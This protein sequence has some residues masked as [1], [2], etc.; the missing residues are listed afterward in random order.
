MVLLRMVGVWIIG[1]LLLL[2]QSVAAAQEP[3]SSRRVDRR[4]P[5]MAVAQRLPP[6]ET[7]S[8]EGMEDGLFAGHQELHVTD[9]VEL[10]VARNPSVEALAHAWRAA[11]QR[12]PQ[13]VSLDDPM[14]MAMMAPA[15]LASQDVEA[16]YVLQGSQKFQLHG[17][18]AAK[19][20]AAAAEA[21]VALNELR[22]A[23]LEVTQMAQFAYYDYYLV[24]QKIALLRQ[25]ARIMREFRDSANSKYENNLVTEQDVLQADIELADVERRQIELDRLNVTAIARINTLLLRIPDD[26]LP[27]PP[28][29][30]I[31][32]H[33]VPPVDFLRQM[34]M[35]QRPDLA[36]V[37]ARVR[38]EQANLT[39]ATKQYYPDADVFGRYD[40]FWQPVATQ[41]DLR[42]Q[43]GV[44]INVPIYHRRLSAGVCE[45]RFRV[46]QRQAEYEQKV[47]DIQYEVQNAY[48]EVQ[49]SQKT[50]EL[51]STKF[52][53]TADRN[54]SVARSNY[55][56]GQITF[57][58]LAQAQR[59]AV[60]LRE[61]HQEALA[62]Y[63]RRLAELERVVGSALPEL[64]S[65]ES[66]ELP[67]PDHK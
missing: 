39:L 65:K 64:A 28:H 51:Y 4:L 58:G 33:E 20:R 67:L 25:N 32:P 2:L 29:Q 45:A 27:P 55:D 17:K 53:P 11:A 34:A 13:V 47:A 3:V 23:R 40:S 54:A 1:G 19:G 63:H 44:N 6:V 37:A 8:I 26:F 24:Q 56:V 35:G 14:F 61:K 7:V 36:A 22:D 48:A 12:Y 62:D 15:S 52:L 59:Q 18:R 46:A 5:A 38:A 16:G 60:E 57:L 42:G 41:S 10:A 50:A 43:V 30:L 49:A 21:R 9:L 66:E 31:I